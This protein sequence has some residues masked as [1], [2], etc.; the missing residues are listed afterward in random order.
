MVQIVCLLFSMPLPLD[1][2]PCTPEA[3]YWCVFD[4]HGLS[5][6][7]IP[8]HPCE[9]SVSLQISSARAVNGKSRRRKYLSQIRILFVLQYD[10]ANQ[11]EY[12]R[13][14]ERRFPDEAGSNGSGREDISDGGVARGC[15]VSPS[16]LKQRQQ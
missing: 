6:G 8:A 11:P 1:E 9:R 3:T 15:R 12:F 14:C 5:S 4:S 10:T 13:G 2:P 7:A 16:L